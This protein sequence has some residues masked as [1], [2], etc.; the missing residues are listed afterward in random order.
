M[1]N[2]PVSAVDRFIDPNKLKL[3]R[4]SAKTQMQLD[5]YTRKHDDIV[6]AFQYAL[7]AEIITPEERLENLLMGV[8]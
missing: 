4:G 2:S 5:M 6:D 1:I 3:P 8:N 7:S